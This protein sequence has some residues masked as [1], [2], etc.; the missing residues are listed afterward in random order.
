MSAGSLSVTAPPRVAGA[1]DA[2]NRAELVLAERWEN[3]REEWAMRECLILLKWEL[4]KETA[5]EEDEGGKEAGF[6]GK[7]TAVAQQDSIFEIAAP[8]LRCDDGNVM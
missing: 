6:R 8:S 3:W 2:K 5:E 4:R 1:A 7:E